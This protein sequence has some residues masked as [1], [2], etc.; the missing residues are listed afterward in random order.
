MLRQGLQGFHME[1]IS[2]PRR[3]QDRP[4]PERLGLHYEGFL[5]A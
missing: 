3:Q 2:M 1:R 5:A 4:D